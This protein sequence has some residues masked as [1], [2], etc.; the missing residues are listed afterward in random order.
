M[1]EEFEMNYVV[2]YFTGAALALAVAL[3]VIAET[4]EEKGL[5]IAQ[6]MDA[7]DMGWGSSET[8]LKMVLNPKGA[9]SRLAV[10]RS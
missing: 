2:K 5:A 4:P 9:S 1:L 10:D 7:R 6:E 3:P 8:V